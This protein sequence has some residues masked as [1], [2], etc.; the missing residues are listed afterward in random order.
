VAIRVKP[1]K[2]APEI[3]HH[4]RQGNRYPF[5]TPRD[6]QSV[7]LVSTLNLKPQLAPQPG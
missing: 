1:D 6:M 7:A 4:W 3:K 2:T 5:C